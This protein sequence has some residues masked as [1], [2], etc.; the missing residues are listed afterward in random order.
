MFFS[1]PSDESKII[2]LPFI[3]ENPSNYSTLHSALKF[4]ATECAKQKRECIVTFDQPLYIK[5]SEIIK[6]ANPNDIIKNI[7]TR[8]GLFHFLMAFL[9]GIGFIMKG[10]GIEDLWE[11][12]YGKNTVQHMMSGHAFSRAIRANLL[13]FAGLCYSIINSSGDLQAATL[14]E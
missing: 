11:K 14:S 3:N 5:A 12:I 6:S 4:A 2:Y 1:G 10:R 9:G 13:T 8:P 7:H